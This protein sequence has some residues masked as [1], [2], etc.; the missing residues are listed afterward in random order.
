MASKNKMN[1]RVSKRRVDVITKKIGDLEKYG[2]P[3][4]FVYATLWT[5]ELCV[6]GDKRMAST[7]KNSQQEFL[8]VL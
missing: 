2:V 8:E 5:G 1:S 4:L 6:V 3:S 7:V